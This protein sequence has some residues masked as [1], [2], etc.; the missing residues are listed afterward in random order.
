MPIKN[1]IDFH[2]GIL[3]QSTQKYEGKEEITRKR[4]NGKR[5]AWQEQKTRKNRKHNKTN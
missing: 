5:G 4:E 3:F 1:K 2:H